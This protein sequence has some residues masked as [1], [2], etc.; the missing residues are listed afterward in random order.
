MA[1]IPHDYSHDPPRLECPRCGGS[2]AAR[3]YES[4]V[5]GCHAADDLLST[6]DRMN[7][8]SASARFA[9]LIREAAAKGAK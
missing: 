9:E 8:N 3:N 1:F 2:I 7:P 6:Y 5:L 4:H